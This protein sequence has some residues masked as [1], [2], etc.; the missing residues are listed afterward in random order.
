[1]DTEKILAHWY[2]YIYDKQETQTDDAQFLVSI[3]GAEPK[4]ILEICCGSGRILVTLAKAGH[5]VTGLD[6]DDEM[7]SKIPAKAE[8]LNNLK[9]YKADAITS[10]WGR[11][12][13]IAVLAGNIMINIETQI[14]YKEAQQLFIRKAADCL[15]Q[16]GYVYLD[17]NLFLQPELFF[18]AIGERVI[19]EGTD[20][21]GVFCR[22]VNLG[23]IYNIETQIAEN[24][25]RKELS[26]PDG[27]QKIMNGWSRK[28]IPTLAQVHSWLD[29]AGFTIEQEYGDYFKNPISEKT[30]RAII[31]A[32][33]TGK[34]S[35]DR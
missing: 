22:C 11:N 8:G 7:M 13:D 18:G 19:F 21:R 32:K 35:I 3:I 10:D 34:N 31:Y 1:M 23:G 9:F 25:N 15:K 30:F 20:D 16:G 33:L 27:T 4:N 17:F 14:D 24:E 26:L 6:M 5:T 29:E 12:F 2:A 28:H